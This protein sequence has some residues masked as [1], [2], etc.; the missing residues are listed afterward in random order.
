L[1]ATS[2]T[3]TPAD[4][5]IFDVTGNL[6]M[7]SYTIRGNTANNA[8]QYSATWRV[9]GNVTGPGN[10]DSYT[11]ANSTYGGHV[12][13]EAGGTI[14]LNRVTTLATAA[15]NGNN[16]GAVYLWATGTVTVATYI[17]TRAGLSGNAGA[18][19]IRSEGPISGQGI[20]I[21][22]SVNSDSTYSDG[23][24]YSILTESIYGQYAG[25]SGGAVSL[26]CRTN[27]TLAA[28]ISTRGPGWYNPGGAVMIR[29]DVTD[30]A[31]R[32]GTVS[33]G[34]TGGI[35]TDTGNTGG[36]VTIRATALQLSGGIWT[37]A[38]CY[39]GTRT[40]NVDI[41]VL[42]NATIGGSID[43][44]MLNRDFS[45]GS[46]GYVKIMARR[47]AV[48]GVDAEGYSIRTWPG[49][50]TNPGSSASV[51]G[52][53][54]VTLTNVDTSA[55]RYKPSNPTNS[56]TSSIVV[57]G[58]IGT[59]RWYNNNAMGNIRLSAVEVQL[60]GDLTNSSATASSVMSIHY[61]TNKWGVVTHLVENG[62]RWDGIASH[63]IGY[64]LASGTNTFT[65][66]VPYAGRSD[67]VGTVLIVQ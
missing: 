53:A 13:I 44:R 5:Y 9:T 22:G 36:N 66:D 52:D 40:G 39:G 46:P 34:G 54:D 18:V 15:Q 7:G 64:Y 6:D 3:G 11:A 65:G 56:M 31:A 57:A 10:F 19:T 20:S 38:Y 61:G 63:N 24:A 1:T 4:P 25:A 33:I 55:E 32:A 16:A 45:Q 67:R 48:L 26:Y 28:G 50:L 27:I 59:G 42:E 23:K 37:T 51:A 49:A 30:G 62:V 17:D 8:N 58:K 2:G 21:S 29:G 47:T 14:A 12:R 41:D 60:G 43:T 35:R